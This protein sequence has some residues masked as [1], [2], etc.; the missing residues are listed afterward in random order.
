MNAVATS[1]DTIMDLTYRLIGYCFLWL[2][3]DI[4]FDKK[5]FWINVQFVYWVRL[6]LS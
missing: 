2:L 3:I 1:A 5:R 4:I 6:M